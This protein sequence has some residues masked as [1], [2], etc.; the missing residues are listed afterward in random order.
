MIK[1]EII[2]LSNNICLPFQRLDK[3][4]GLEFIELNKEFATK[5]LAEHGLG[6][7]IN[8]YDL[9]RLDDQW[10]PVPL[11]KT[12]FDTG[13]SNLTFLHNLDIR[14]YNIYDV[15]H[16]LLSHWHYDHTG[17]LYPLLERKKDGIQIICHNN[18]KFERFFR[19][20]DDI[21]NSDLEGKTREEILPLLS[22]SKIV[23][24]EPID[25]KRIQK[26]NAKIFFSKTRYE[27]L[28]IK[29]LR[30]ILSGEIPRTHKIEDFDNFFSL[31]NGVLEVD[32]ILDDKCLIFEFN[33]NVILLNGCC[34]AGLMNTLDYVKNL[35]DKP[36]TH[37][38]G[39]VHMASASDEKIRETVEYLRTFQ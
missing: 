17:A 3:D 13:G 4:Y 29:G 14:G 24:Q 34:H 10:N 27:L 20:S 28:D 19:R 25:L 22:A 39:G 31:Q 1:T 9:D 32:K 2:L 33:E 12:I 36:I 26:S 16:I 38:I 15:N 21:S 37:I 5:S 6:F 7:L 23:N 8:I 11:L 35:T 30:V 18:A